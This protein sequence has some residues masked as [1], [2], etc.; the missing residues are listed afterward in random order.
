MHEH[1]LRHAGAPTKRVSKRMEPTDCNRNLV[2]R[3][4]KKGMIGLLVGNIFG[5]IQKWHER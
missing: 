1:T 5:L 2:E 4:R 3:Q